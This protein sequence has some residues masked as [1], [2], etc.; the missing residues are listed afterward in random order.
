MSGRWY[1]KPMRI[2]A[3]QCNFE[4]GDAFTVLDKWADLGFNV[5]Q[6]FHPMADAYSAIYEESRHGE[7]L[8]RYI[9]R[10][11]S[12]GLRII[13]YL[14]VHILLPSQEAHRDD[15]A[16]RTADGTFIKH[17]GTYYAICVNS[18]WMDYF[19]KVLDGVGEL[20]V[21]GI[22]LDGPSLAAE[23][24]CEHC[25]QQNR[26][27]HGADA[28]FPG[29]KTAFYRRTGN[30]FLRKSYEHFK[31]LKPEA[32]FYVNQSVT[33]LARCKGSLPE[34]LDYND[35]LGTEGGFMFYTQPKYASLWDPSQAAKM[36]E[37]L[38]P[39]KPRVVFM[40][41]D[42][43]PWSWYIHTPAET[44]LCMAST[45]ANGANV[46]YGLH[47][48]TELLGM[49]GGR[50][51]VEMIRFMADNEQYYDRAVSEARIALMYSYATEQF[52]QT[53]ASA[54]DFYGSTRTDNPA[55]PGNMTDAFHGFFDLMTRSSI[56]FDAITDHALTADKLSR[57][58]LLIL[59]TS[60]GLSDQTIATI[61]QF[62]RGGGNL[63]ASGD[64]TL[65]T[66]AGE[67]RKDF[68]LA[69][70]F[71][72]SFAGRFT[73]YASHNYVTRR[74][75][76]PLTDPWGIPLVPAP[77]FGID[78][79][80]RDGAAVLASFHEAMDGPYV[81][82]SPIGPPAVVL[83]RFGEGTCLYLAGTFGELMITHSPVEYR[84]MLEAATGSLAD[85][86]VR[87]EGG[88]GN[89]EMV[90][91]RQGKRRVVHL[92]N[93]AALPPRPFEAIAPQ[94]GVRL[95][96]SARD[97]FTSARALWAKQD[98]PISRQGDKIVVSLPEIAAYEVVVLE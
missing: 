89:I 97:G 29:D 33:N 12:R 17:Y 62:V 10:A 24:H 1:D 48:S 44:Q 21:D 43:K 90:V 82:L 9:E 30:E 6:L 68:G 70:V 64:T 3:L 28:P 39:S 83:N 49:P 93:Y 92:V 79:K 88:L 23:C 61:R 71:G 73:R 47:G 34:L 27:W 16:Q 75:Q 63:I 55:V 85:S 46:W 56:P 53:G 36:L 58:H 54:S 25:R 45:V 65:Y 41:A 81:P 26:Q 18:P 22:F 94:R 35:I 66:P 7:L 4:K 72:A 69:D 96:M 78:V 86:P 20:D 37:A 52:Y 2:A 80:P 38:A 50:A 57:Y 76:H 8:R 77:A 5:E 51:G 11:K 67:V 59:P 32:L 91:R 15:W 42:Q 40:A 84:R 13:L 98:C 87:R 95:V 14:N 60:A 19:L 74:G 31:R